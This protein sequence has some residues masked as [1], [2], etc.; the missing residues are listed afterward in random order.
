LC[1]I[2]VPCG[3]CFDECVEDHEEFSHA[4]G[5]NDFEGFALG[6]EALCEAAEYL[7]FPNTEG[8]VMTAWR[9]AFRVGSGGEDLWPDCQR[10]GVAAMEYRPLDDIDLSRYPEGEPRAAWKKLAPSQQTSLKRLVYDMAEGDVI[11]VKE[12]PI[13]VGKGVVTGP[14]HF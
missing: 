1:I 9:M 3:V 5:H 11:Y 14:Y 12:G 4:G 10:L 2:G 13:I 7:V 8:D 6:F